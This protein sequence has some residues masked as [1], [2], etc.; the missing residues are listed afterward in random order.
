MELLPELVTSFLV[1][2]ISILSQKE[3]GLGHESSREGMEQ[4][5][6]FL[7]LTVCDHAAKEVKEIVNQHQLVSEFVH[8]VASRHD[9]DVQLLS[10]HNQEARHGLRKD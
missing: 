7:V 6:Q 10:H 3:D 2:Q 1:V 4:L 9:E 5:T 8:L